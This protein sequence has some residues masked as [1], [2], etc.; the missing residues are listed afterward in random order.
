[1]N[2]GGLVIVALGVVF[3]LFPERIARSRLRGATD[4]TPTAGAVRQVRWVGG[5]LLTGV[6]LLIVF[7]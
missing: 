5:P 1:M 4:P 6:G 7:A 3:M 2:V